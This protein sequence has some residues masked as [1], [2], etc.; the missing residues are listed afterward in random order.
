L[1]GSE[2]SGPVSC[3]KDHVDLSDV[4]DF[5]Q[6]LAAIGFS[7]AADAILDELIEE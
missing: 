6:R 3:A 5:L 4:K 2:K 7:E 1:Y